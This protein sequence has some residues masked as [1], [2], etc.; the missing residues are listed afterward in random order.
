MKQTRNSNDSPGM[1]T[2]REY[3][4]LDTVAERVF[5]D[6]TALAAYI[7][8]VP[9]A[10]ISFGDETRQWFKS[11]VGINEQETPREAVFCAQ[12][13]L[14]PEPLIVNDACADARFAGNKLITEE[15]QIRFFAGFPL[16]SPAGYSLG[17]LCTVKRAPHQLSERQ[18]TAMKY[19]S[20]Q[21][22]TLLELRRL[23]ARMAQTLENMMP[24]S[25][26]RQVCCLCHRVH[27]QA[28][29]WVTPEV[30]LREHLQSDVHP[31]VCPDCFRH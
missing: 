24:Q 6:V 15:P 20:R 21:V 8:D 14:H 18:Q 9:I 7:C 29:E 27:D 13:I 2:L 19:L 28:G 16:V 30:F 12:T 26:Q 25:E 3:Y 4:V 10:M 22:M 23:S 17:A 11:K 31:V 5:D 1:A